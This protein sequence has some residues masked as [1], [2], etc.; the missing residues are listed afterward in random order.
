MKKEKKKELREADTRKTFY[1][2]LDSNS[3]KVNKALLCKHENC[4]TSVRKKE[5]FDRISV[6]GQ[7]KANIKYTQRK[8][9]S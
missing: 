9:I 5:T 3:H 4:N 7:V 2:E 8:S 1:A 6:K